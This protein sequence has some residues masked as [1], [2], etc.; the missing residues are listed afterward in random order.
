MPTLIIILQRNRP[1]QKKRL[2]QPYFH[3]TWLPQSLV[4]F[5]LLHCEPGLFHMV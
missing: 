3:L 4:R 2:A 1:H 5:S